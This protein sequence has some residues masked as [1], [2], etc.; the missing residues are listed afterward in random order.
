MATIEQAARRLE[1]ALARLRRAVAERAANA[2][3][4]DR[5]T[6]LESELAEALALTDSLRHDRREAVRELDR[7]IDGLEAALA[8]DRQ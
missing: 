3:E 7:A 8:P 2:A 5:H 4:G 6:R 1:K